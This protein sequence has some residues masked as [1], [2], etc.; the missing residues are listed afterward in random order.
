MIL[1]STIKNLR[2]KIT[3]SPY[4]PINE[5]SKTA[6]DLYCRLFLSSHCKEPNDGNNNSVEE[7]PPE[8]LSRSKELH[9]FLKKKKEDV[10]SG[11]LTPQ[12]TPQQVLKCI[13]K[14]MA[15]L[16][17]TEQRP[18]CLEKVYQALRTIPPSSTEAERSFSAAGLFVTKLRTRLNDDT[19][20]ELF[21]LC[22]LLQNDTN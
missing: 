17:C 22:C 20:D 4:P 8:K 7:K 15:V 14:E 12:S 13:K 5:L 2:M 11:M 9:I 16:E 19:I 6:R 3:A 18:S 1:L 21:F 10:T